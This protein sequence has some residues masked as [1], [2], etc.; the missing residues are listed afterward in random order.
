[1]M[2]PC[3]L[4]NND[5]ASDLQE[6]KFPPIEDT[7]SCVS[8]AFTVSLYPLGIQ[9]LPRLLSLEFET[10]LQVIFLPQ[11]EADSKE[12]KAERATNLYLR[13]NVNTPIYATD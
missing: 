3:L 13:L 6:E 12:K 9:G 4:F 5:K 2:L 1:M 11:S 8:L 7:R 10:A